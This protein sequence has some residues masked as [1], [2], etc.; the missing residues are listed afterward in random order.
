MNNLIIITENACKSFLDNLKTDG[1]ENKYI[2][3]Y[4]KGGRM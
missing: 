3:I 2:R 4:V 1:S